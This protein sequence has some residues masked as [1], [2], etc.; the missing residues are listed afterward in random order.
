MTNMSESAMNQKNNLTQYHSLPLHDKVENEKDMLLKVL[1]V[2]KSFEVNKKHIETINLY[3]KC[4][5][6]MERTYFALGRKKKYHFT[7]QSTTNGKINTSSVST[8]SEI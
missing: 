8:T 3:R 7:P 2:D 5:E 1:P 4:S 6:L